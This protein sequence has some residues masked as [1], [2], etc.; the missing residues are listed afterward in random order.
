M[1]IYI[2]PYKKWI[3]PFQL[4][5]PLRYIGVSEFYR[6][7]IADYFSNGLITS[8]CEWIHSKRNRKVKIKLHYYDTWNMDG[9]L[10]III[11]PML[12]KLKENTHGAPNVDDDDVPIELKSTSVPPVDQYGTD[13]NHFK[14]WDYA[15]DE[16]IWAFEQLNPENNWEDKFF[17]GKSKITWKKIPNKFKGEEDLEMLQIEDDDTFKFDSEGYDVH[18]ARIKN[19]I[20]LFGKYYLSLW[21]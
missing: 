18:F 7:K 6:D 9:T 1:K 2:G 19:G 20:R 14:R 17:T 10:A 11:A 13:E 12:K 16:M 3:G 4:V 21:D 5:E 8:A 15:L